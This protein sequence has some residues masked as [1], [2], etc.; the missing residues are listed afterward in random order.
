MVL[1]YFC[2]DSAK[3]P[4]EFP[5]SAR[6]MQLTGGRMRLACRVWRP[7]EHLRPTIISPSNGSPDSGQRELANTPLLRVLIRVYW[8]PFVVQLNG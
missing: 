7:A 2:C 5:A 6:T 8:C 1:C 3:E 4:R